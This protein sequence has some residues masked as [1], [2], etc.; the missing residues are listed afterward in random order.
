MSYRAYLPRHA[1]MPAGTARAIMSI[2]LV[3]IALAF[4]LVA[5]AVA[6]EAPAVIQRPAVSA[7]SNSSSAGPAPRVQ[8][9]APASTAPQKPAQSRPA[10]AA[11]LYTVRPGDSLWEISL[12]VYGTGMRWG[13]I[14]AASRAVVGAD[15]GH[16]VPGERLVVPLK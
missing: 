2:R 6:H 10:P 7:P 15:P 12:A 9:P 11:V 16:L 3:L 4:G 5:L 13:R 14:Y 8:V 1:W